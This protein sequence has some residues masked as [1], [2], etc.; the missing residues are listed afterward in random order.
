MSYVYYYLMLGIISF[1]G[2]LIVSWKTRGEIT[3]N[4]L[5][6]AI[7]MIAGW[8][9]LIVGGLLGLLEYISEKE[10]VLIRRK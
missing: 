5:F 4:T 8:P 10:I 1:T 6:F 7:A 2:I 9:A 3:L